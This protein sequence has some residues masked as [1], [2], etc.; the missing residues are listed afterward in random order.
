[1][2]K[3][4]TPIAFDARHAELIVLI[5][6]RIAVTNAALIALFQHM[7]AEALPKKAEQ[8]QDVLTLTQFC[9]R[10]HMGKSKFYHLVK[11]GLAPEFMRYGKEYRITR[12]AE[13][14]W[15]VMMAERTK[16][17]DER[18]E[19]ERRSTAAR[20]AAKQTKLSLQKSAR[21]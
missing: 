2:T 6:Q 14:A 18:L 20:K 4:I 13:A 3:P 10:N 8:E 15:R 9:K 21:Q 19:H 12:A 5:D 11:V 7:I 16:S 1:V 17:V